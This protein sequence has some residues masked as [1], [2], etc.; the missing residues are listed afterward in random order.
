VKASK[1]RP[2]FSAEKEAKRLFLIWGWGGDSH[3]SRPTSILFRIEGS[4]FVDHSTTCVL[5]GSVKDGEAARVAGLSLIER[6]KTQTIRIDQC[7][8]PTPL[9]AFAS[10]PHKD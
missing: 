5:P 10:T 8:T 1:A 4:A 2:S 3:A 7:I 6:G 9:E